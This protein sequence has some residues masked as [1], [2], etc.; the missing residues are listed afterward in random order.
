[1]SLTVVTV[2]NVAKFAMKMVEDDI[3]EIVKIHLDA[4]GID[5]E[6]SVNGSN[7]VKNHRIAPEV[8]WDIYYY[9]HQAPTLMK[10]LE[11]N[12]NNDDATRILEWRI[13]LMLEILELVVEFVVTKILLLLTL[14][15]LE[16]HLEQRIL[17]DKG[18]YCWYD[19]EEIKFCDDSVDEF[20]AFF[21]LYDFNV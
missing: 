8:P 15:L 6:N 17:R 12:K 20:E 5:M 1:M 19:D 16:R 18:R 7:T 11:T 2:I 4:Y 14:N 10:H 9:A 3:R 13:S 21:Y